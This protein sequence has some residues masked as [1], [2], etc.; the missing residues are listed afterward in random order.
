MSLPIR[1]LFRRLTASLLAASLV[2]A[3]P[4]LARPTPGAPA[5]S[6]TPTVSAGTLPS[7]AWGQLGMKKS[8]AKERHRVAEDLAEE[9]DDLPAAQ[10]PG[11][12][13]R[14][15]KRRW[16]REHRGQRQLELVVLSDSDDP[17]MTALQAR[18]AEL[19]GEV[20]AVFP[21]LR[22]V[23]VL[24][25]KRAVRR[26]ARHP[27]VVSIAPNRDTQ[28]SASTLEVVAGATVA[29]VRS[30]SSATAYSGLDGSG[31]RI[32]ILDS[33][34]M[35]AHRNFRNAAGTGSRVVR[36][37][38]MLKAASLAD[39][40]Y[41]IWG[42]P[43]PGSPAQTSFDTLVAADLDITQDAHGHGTHVASVAAGRGFYQ[44]PNSTGI[45]PGA[46]L[47]DVRVTGADGT[48]TVADALKGINWVIYN[49]R[50]LNIRVMNI[51]LAASST[52]PWDYDPLCAAVRC[53]IGRAS[54]RERV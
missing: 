30:Y 53:K 26:L 12:G 39:S 5:G 31:V 36:S 34:V 40:A 1:D 28:S 13:A 47:V 20:Q 42:T 17:G 44:Q 48:G 22:S 35:K 24:M 15:E 23:S 50:A 9:V 11:R 51:S 27:D 2:T 3:G 16:A 54:C 37:V 25:P 46:E 45:A 8:K 4:A 52:D 49:A 10:R 21:A 19:G 32:A 14:A 41:S 33:G 18:V 7:Q 43:M 38:S 29:P 6:P